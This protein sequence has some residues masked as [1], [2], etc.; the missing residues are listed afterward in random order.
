MPGPLALRV[1]ACAIALAGIVLRLDGIGRFGFWNDE[2]WVATATRVEGLRQFLVALSVTPIGWGALLEP[3]SHAPGRPETALRL[4]PAAFG[5]ATLWLSWRLGARLAGHALGGLFALAL[6]AFDP[7]GIVWAQQLKPYTAEA[8]L[9]LAAFLAAAAVARRPGTRQIAVLAVVLT[10][11]LTLSNAQ[12]FLAPPVF[13]ALG[14]QALLRRDG[15]A[16]RRLV[17]AGAL[18]ALWDLT[19]FALV[20]DPWLTPVLREYWNGHYAPRGDPAA[21]LRFGWNA[22]I[23]LL[24]PGL[25]RFGPWLAFAGLVL[26]L[27]TSSGRWP[28]MA[29]VLLVA[30]L[31][32]LSVAQ[33]FPLDVH[34]TGLF[35]STLVLVTTG[36]AAGHLVALLASRPALRPLALATTG[37]LLAVVAWTHASPGALRNRP[38]DLGPLLQTVERER[39]AG[40]RILLYDRSVF[41]WGYYRTGTPVLVPND[42]LANGYVVAVDD[43]DV[44]LVGST[45]IDAAVERALAGGTRVWFVGSRFRPTDEV[46]IRFALARRG[47][48]TQ[49]ERRER[50]LLL[51]VE[52][53]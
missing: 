50:A 17:I 46:R 19:W 27:T 42:G 47:R 48:I 1:L 5:V 18:V 38:E 23:M 25:G 36:A 32:G 13:L 33:M 40:D 22:A 43:P 16:L 3:L 28:A 29:A 8:A 53:P 49:E 20:I 12:L 34:R 44:V 15:P 9:A 2:A 41:V 4:L 7:A 39:L 45:N 24:S 6:V 35:V 31:L 21:I 52:R 30:Q 11:G 10:L 26:L 51:R 37:A 14:L